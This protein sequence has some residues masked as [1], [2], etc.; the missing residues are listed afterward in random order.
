MRNSIQE[1]YF[2]LLFDQ[3]TRPLETTFTRARAQNVPQA[4]FS[5]ALGKLPLPSL[6]QLSRQSFSVVLA[7]QDVALFPLL[8]PTIFQ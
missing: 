7:A 2:L 3:F 5:H 6:G 1:L 4:V 8:V